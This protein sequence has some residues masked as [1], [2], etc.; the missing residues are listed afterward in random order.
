MTTA[1]VGAKLH[2]SPDLSE[3]LTF[4]RE[5]RHLCAL[6][7]HLLL[8]KGPNLSKF[9][10]IIDLALER[11]GL[12]PVGPLDASEN[13]HV[14]AEFA[15]LRDHWERLADGQRSA[16]LGSLLGRLEHVR[17]IDLGSLNTDRAGRPLSRIGHPGQWW[18][19]QALHELCP[20]TP[21]GDAAFREL[22]LLKWAFNAK[23]DLVVL[24]PDTRPLC[25]EAK[26]FSP[27]SRYPR[28]ARERARF[29]E[30]NLPLVTQMELQGFL[31]DM[32]GLPAQQVCITRRSPTSADLPYLTWRQVFEAMECS[33]SVDF[34]SQSVIRNRHL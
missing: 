23:P 20:R 16:Y 15:Y 27:A 24:V 10:E 13:V 5:E 25:I 7:F 1:A 21:E 9:I 3:Y 6:L 31:Y 12:A 8:C 11:C 2:S 26:L 14:F 17:D 33:A 34:V 29:S 4:V 19:V 32:L 30:R 18:S 28:A 22:C